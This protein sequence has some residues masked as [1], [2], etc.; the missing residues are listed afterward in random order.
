MSKY[1]EKKITNYMNNRN[2]INKYINMI[3]HENKKC[4]SVDP[5]NSGNS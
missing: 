2:N 4:I 5:T 3:E 1:G